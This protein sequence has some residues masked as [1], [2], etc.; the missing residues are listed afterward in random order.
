MRLFASVSLLAMTLAACATAGSPPPA[1]ADA[2]M[3][4]PSAKSTAAPTAE[5]AREFIAMV[6]KDLFD[7]SVIGSRAGW[8]NATYINDDTDALAAYFG[9]I[10]TEKGVKYALEAA[11]FAQVPGLDSDTQRKLNILRGGLVL[12]APTTPGAAAEL[13][14]IATR[15]QS[16]YGK[17][18][19]SLKGKVLTGD[20]VEAL[21]GTNR[22]P[23]ELAEMWQTWHENVGRPMRADYVRMVE[24]ANAGAKELGYDDSGAMWRGQY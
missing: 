11:K 7:L 20:D 18:R 8:V 9:T 4:V 14:T 22:N 19:A 16:T 15:L 1:A 12:P 5:Q 10:G 3:P 6:E 21:M 13:N 2:A 24:I 17:G 23:A